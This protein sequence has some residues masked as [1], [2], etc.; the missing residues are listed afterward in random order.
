[1]DRLKKIPLFKTEDEEMEFW[2]YADSSEFVNW[3]KSNRIVLP[4]LKPCNK[5]ISQRVP[6]HLLD[7]INIID[8]KQDVP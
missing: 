1:M 3:K 2:A 8:S 7:E 6:Q 4:N 5:T